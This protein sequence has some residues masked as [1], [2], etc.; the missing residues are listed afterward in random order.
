MES[1]HSGEVNF[2]L[3]SH[4]AEE[5]GAVWPEGTL[6]GREIRD[7]RLEEETWKGISRGKEKWL[8]LKMKE[9]GSF[10]TYRLK[11]YS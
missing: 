1:G 3:T 4:L 11:A 7:F 10:G 8:G 9:K 5:E 2:D 6:V